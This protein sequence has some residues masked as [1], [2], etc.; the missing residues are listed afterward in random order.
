VAAV[1]DT[2]ASAGTN[3]KRLA[4]YFLKLGAVGFGGPVALTGAMHRDLVATRRWVSPDDFREGMALAQLAP[5]PL[6]A[7]LAMYIG[8]LAGGVS[9]AA[10]I[11]TAFVLPSLIMVWAIS[12]AYVS[13]GGL[14]WMAA[15]FYGVNATVIAIMLRASWKLAASTMERDWLLWLM[16]V[17]TALATIVLEREVVWL[18]VAAGVVNWVR[19]R[20]LASVPAFSVVPMFAFGVPA[21]A[22]IST[23]LPDI[24]WFFTQAGAS[25][26][27]SGLAIVPFLYGGA[28]RELGWLTDQQFLDAVAVAMITPGPVVITVAFI[29]YLLRGEAGMLAAALGVFLPVFLFVVLPARHFRRI[30]A[31][32]EARA[33]VRGVTAAA[34]GAL[35]GATVVLATRAWIDVWTLCLGLA[36]CAVLARWRAPELLIIAGG[37]AAGLL[38]H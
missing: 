17:A 35:A 24:F 15:V 33:F 32:P 3:L 9:G 27:G 21:S 38:V 11:G 14:A 10:L 23:S 37:A 8:Y 5:G 34:S 25:V 20:R 1:D 30:T 7:Q 6:A 28:V 13:Y 19:A 12:A 36:C 31:R 4:C 18:F 2:D 22:A 26:F 29:G 16:A